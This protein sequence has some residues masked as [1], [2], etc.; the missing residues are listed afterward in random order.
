MSTDKVMRAALERIAAH[1]GE[2]W[3]AW[4]DLPTVPQQTPQEIATAALASVAP[5]AS[6]KACRACACEWTGGNTP[7]T[8]PLCGEAAVV[9][10]M[11]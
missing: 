11:P 9:K 4:D 5:P 2:R 7:D 3:E 6:R 8:C 1:D 10:D